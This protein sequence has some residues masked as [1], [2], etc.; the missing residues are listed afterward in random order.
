MAALLESDILCLL[1]GSSLITALIISLLQDVGQNSY[2]GKVAD[3]LP[4][5]KEKVFLQN[6]Q[7]N[8]LSAYFLNHIFELVIYWNGSWKTNAD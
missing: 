7:F 1:Q 4:N 5:F 3:F 2:L 6:I 8:L